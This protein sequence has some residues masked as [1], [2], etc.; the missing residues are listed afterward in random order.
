MIPRKS[1]ELLVRTILDI[2]KTQFV[3]LKTN[4]ATGSRVAKEFRLL[5]VGTGSGCILIASIRSI[6]SLPEYNPADVSIFG[7]GTDISPLALDVAKKNAQKHIQSQESL[8]CFAEGDME[9]LH[10]DPL[11][12]Q[13]KFDIIVCN[14]PYLDILTPL[15]PNDLRAHEPSHAIFCQEGGYGCYRALS[16]SLH[17]SFALDSEVLNKDGLV[18]LEVGATMAK[19]VKSMFDGWHCIKSMKDQQGFERC[20]VFKRKE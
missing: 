5:D 16:E 3:R 13:K 7:M 19:K 1:T 10:N 11:L 14:P 9:Y 17:K 15:P 12:F 6:L 18:I 4:E 20:L 8:Y 2:Y